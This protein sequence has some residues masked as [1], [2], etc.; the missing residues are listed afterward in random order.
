MNISLIEGAS[1]LLNLCLF[2]RNIY[3]KK[4]FSFQLKS[5]DTEDANRMNPEQFLMGQK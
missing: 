1:D 2:L 5:I 4:I 3:T